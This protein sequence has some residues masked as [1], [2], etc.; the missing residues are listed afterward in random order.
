MHNSAL[1]SLA[2]W[3]SVFSFFPLYARMYTNDMVEVLSVFSL[4]F[5]LVLDEE[6]FS[7]LFSL[8]TPF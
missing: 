2:F 7:V 8:T 5:S 1:R 4:L 3:I 6:D